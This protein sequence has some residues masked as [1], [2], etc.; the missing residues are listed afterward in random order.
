MRSPY[1]AA[2]RYAA[3]KQV[4]FADLILGSGRITVQ[5]ISVWGEGAKASPGDSGRKGE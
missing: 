2:R 5:M 4:S 1:D 3:T